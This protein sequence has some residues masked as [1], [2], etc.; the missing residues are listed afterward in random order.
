MEASVL[1]APPVNLRSDS[2]GN[3]GV[4]TRAV[5]A[6]ASTQAGAL[7][8]AGCGESVAILRSLDGSAAL[9]LAACL[10]PCAG[11]ILSL[12]WGDDGNRLLCVGSSSLVVLTKDEPNG[13]GETWSVS[14]RMSPL[15]AAG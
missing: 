12:Q 15:G 13:E 10:F 5:A 7:V 1:I 11:R 6:F 3:T 4:G 2:A 14:H 8:G 9:S